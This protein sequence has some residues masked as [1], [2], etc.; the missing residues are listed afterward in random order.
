MMD[1]TSYMRMM[2]YVVGEREN[3]LTD[4]T[5]GRRNLLLW[6]PGVS[7]QIEAFLNRSI[8]S[9]SRTE[10]H[11]LEYAQREFLVAAYPATT[12]TSVY[13]D[14]TGL[15][16]GGETEITDCFIGVGGRSVWL[17]DQ[18]NTI[19][20]KGIRIIYTGGLA[21]HGVRSTFTISTSAGTWHVNKY[22]TGGT[23]R[24]MG[25]VRTASSTSIVVEVLYG[26]FV[27]GETLTE[28]D[29]ES[30]T[31]AS[32]A[33]A[34][35]TTKAA[36]ALCEA[37]PEITLAT[38]MQIRFMWKHKLDFE[39]TTITKDGQTLRQTPS[40]SAEFPIRQEVAAMLNNYRRLVV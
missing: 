16:D 3:A 38:E 26:V 25:Y 6:I 40:I 30:D 2:R 13:Y 39:N 28:M 32:D 37:Y 14:S 21:A 29:S 31:G 18:L 24:A 1:L 9:T 12:L 27:A 22:V 10:Y 5:A 33:V 4:D 34:T 20:P 15:W 36:T 23:S 11:D 35:L 19:S 7:A 17:P 8:E